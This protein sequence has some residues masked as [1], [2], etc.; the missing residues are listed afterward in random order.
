[1]D[2]QSLPYL[3]NVSIHPDNRVRELTVD[4]MIEGPESP[5][6]E[7]QVFK[8]S[9]N[10]KINLRLL[11][12]YDPNQR[13][14]V[15]RLLS[16]TLSVAVYNRRLTPPRF[17]KAIT[18]KS[19]LI[20]D[21]FILD[22][23]ILQALLSFSDSG[24]IQVT[25][26]YP[27]AVPRQV[28]KWTLVDS[29]QS[30]TGLPITTN[31]KCRQV[32]W[33]GRIERGGLI[34]SRRTSSNLLYNRPPKIL[35]L[36]TICLPSLSRCKHIRSRRHICLSWLTRL[37]YGSKFWSQSIFGYRIRCLFSNTGELIFA[38]KHLTS[39]ELR[40]FAMCCVDRCMVDYLVT[41]LIVQPITWHHQCSI[42]TAF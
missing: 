20:H 34:G 39:S 9:P 27:T 17:F 7:S 42:L 28:I 13:Y 31:W 41:N 24:H 21:I 29:Q 1:M 4:R 32:P 40:K 30:E 14:F 23:F 11:R 26:K 33:N 18:G 37:P 22:S 12:W 2:Y 10:Y 36:P 8:L 3:L 38:V 25:G 16:N 5:P 6:Y 15:R 35:L 19:L